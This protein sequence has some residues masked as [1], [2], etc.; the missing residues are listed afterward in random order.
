MRQE[1][2]VM[3]QRDSTSI[4]TPYELA[5]LATRLYPDRCASDIQ[6]ALNDAVALLKTAANTLSRLEKEEKELE[7]SVDAIRF[8]WVR[9]IKEITG[10]PRRD[11]ATR[12][13]TEFM[14]HREPGNDLSEYQSDGFTEREVYGDLGPDFFNWKNKPKRKKRKQGHRTSDSD[15]RL[16]T[17]LVGLVPTKPRKRG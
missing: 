2:T 6:R 14:K 1:K 17:E 3:K 11:R 10:E 15:G 9:G 8:D 13:F 5:T 7:E 16:R 12:R 4:A